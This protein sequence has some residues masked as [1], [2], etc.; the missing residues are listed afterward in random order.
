MKRTR[1]SYWLGASFAAVALL[2][3]ATARADDNPNSGANTPAQPGQSDT[4]SEQR[5][6]RISGRITAVDT[7]AQTI[8]V[9]G[10]LLSKVIKVGSDAQIAIEGNTS[11]TLSDLKVDDRVAV[12]YH[13]EGDTLTAQRITR[14]AS[15]PK[16]SQGGSSSST[17]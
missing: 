9:K 8:T 10:L 16:E 17:Y 1:H 13:A 14:T 3:V 7:G 15:G 4:S 2:L 5:E 11:A 12:S 6:Q